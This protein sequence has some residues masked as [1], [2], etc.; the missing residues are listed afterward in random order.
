MRGYATHPLGAKNIEFTERELDKE[1]HLNIFK[2]IDCYVSLS[3]GEGFSIQ[4]REAMV[5]GI[6]VIVTNNTGQT[7]ICNSHFV[8]AVP[9][10]DEVPGFYPIYTNYYGVFYDC[11]LED[12]AQALKDVY[13]NYDH[14][15]QQGPA[16]REW[17]KQYTY[18]QLKPLYLGLLN[19]KRIILGHENKVTPDFLSTDSSELCE[20]FNQLLGIPFDTQINP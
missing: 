13:N 5:L 18:E 10:M 20:K 17:V 7:T 16:A 11:K 6:P 1:N 12:A 9:S 14:Y 4:P 2:N 15:L 19:P 3:S 8:K